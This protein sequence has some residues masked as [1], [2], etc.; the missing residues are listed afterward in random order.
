MMSSPWK[1]KA[2]DVVADRVLKR[3]EVSKVN[4]TYPPLPLVRDTDNGRLDCS[5]TPEPT[6][7]RTIQDPEGLGGFYAGQY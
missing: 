5:Q 6:R 3:V 1:E 2:P 4:P 7:T